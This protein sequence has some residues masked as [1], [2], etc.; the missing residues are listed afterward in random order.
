MENRLARLETM[1]RRLTAA[2]VLLALCIVGFAAMG[3]QNQTKTVRA[4]QFV[5]VDERGKT[6]GMFA[7]ARDVPTLELLTA[8]GSGHIRLEVIKDLL[9][10]SM[11]TDGKRGGID[12]SSSGS[13]QGGHIEVSGGEKAVSMH[14]AASDAAGFLIQGE[15]A[16]TRLMLHLDKNGMIGGGMW[17]KDRMPV[18]KAP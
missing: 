7:M 17:D 1:N 11:A 4:E 3:A 5:L 9:S 10:L 16:R 15:Y 8:D 12:M 18:W 6:R 14:A 2:L 13:V